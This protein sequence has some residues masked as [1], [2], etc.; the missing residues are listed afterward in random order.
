MDEMTCKML[1]CDITLIG[2]LTVVRLKFPFKSWE[3]TWLTRDLKD[4][5]Y[6]LMTALS[7]RA[8]PPSL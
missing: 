7:V 1:S 3:P 8:K 5:R 4:P 6:L 2:K